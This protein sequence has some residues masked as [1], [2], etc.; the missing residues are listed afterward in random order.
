[1]VK[2]RPHDLYNMPKLFEKAIHENS[3]NGDEEAIQE[4]KTIDQ[5]YPMV[6][7]DNNGDDEI[8]LMRNNIELIYV[9]SNIVD[10]NDTNV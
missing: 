2:P 3:Q 6:A 8:I 9:D 1:M 5:I 10:D 4:N 7:I